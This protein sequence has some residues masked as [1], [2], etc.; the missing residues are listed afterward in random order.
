M[1]DTPNTVTH[2]NLDSPAAKKKM[3]KGLKILLI[4]TSVL[5]L[6]CVLCSGLSYFVFWP[7]MM[8]AA[9]EQAK[10]QIEDHETVKDLI[11]DIESCKYSVGKLSEYMNE[12]DSASGKS[13]AAYEVTGSKGS[14]ILIGEVEL[15]GTQMKNMIL[16]V[17]GEEHEL[18]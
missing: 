12:N 10:A 15:G 2:P 8:N 18:D 5:V 7:M 14:G 9:G 16:I 11:G 4:L 17:D 6:S 3:S 13:L 1:S